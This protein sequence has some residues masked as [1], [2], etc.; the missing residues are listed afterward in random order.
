MDLFGVTASAPCE[1]GLQAGEAGSIPT[2]SLRGGLSAPGRIDPPP[3]ELLETVEGEVQVVLEAPRI[4]EVGAMLLIQG[5]EQA[6]VIPTKAPHPIPEALLEREPPLSIRPRE[7]G[8]GRRFTHPRRLH[9][10]LGA[11]LDELRVPDGG[12][13]GFAHQ[14]LAGAYQNQG[15]EEEGSMTES[16]ISKS[17]GQSGHAGMVG[18]KSAEW[19]NIR[20]LVQP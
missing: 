2:G 5:R 13:G 11:E 3:G 14:E 12:V 9:P 7:L 1:Y 10:E 18:R 19:M 15:H 4:G 6:L 17:V 16:Q 20:A 8:Q